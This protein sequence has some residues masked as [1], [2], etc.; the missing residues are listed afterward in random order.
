MLWLSQQYAAASSEADR[1]ALVA[2]GQTLLTTYNGT[3]FSVGYFLSG[4]AMLL[5]SAVMLRRAVF[6]RLTGLAGV[7]AGVTGL[8]PASF[9]T[10]GFVLSLISLLPLVVWLALIGRRFVRLGFAAD[11]RAAAT[12]LA[13]WPG[14]EE[15]DA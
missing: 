13:G 5:V 2:A 15:E 1:A 4:L 11:S 3:A 10:L 7:L 6:S 12:G 8:V 14:L 9:G